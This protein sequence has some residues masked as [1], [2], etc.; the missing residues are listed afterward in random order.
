MKCDFCGNEHHYTELRGFP[1]PNVEAIAAFGF[2][3]SGFQKMVKGM[4]PEQQV[5]SY[6]EEIVSRYNNDDSWALC[7]TCQIEMQKFAQKIMKSN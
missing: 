4:V 1:H 5:A 2:V 7:S 3:P 6:F